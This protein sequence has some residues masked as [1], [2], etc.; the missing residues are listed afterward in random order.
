MQSILTYRRISV[1]AVAALRDE[2]QAA[3][4]AATCTMSSDVMSQVQ[5]LPRSYDRSAQ[6]IHK[7]RLE[8][9][10]A[11]KQSI[12]SQANTSSYTL[13]VALKYAGLNASSCSSLLHTRTPEQQNDKTV[14]QHICWH[15][16][17]TLT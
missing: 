4:A 14:A 2:P 5:A 7:M 1:A 12:T 11:W 9:T 6:P 15:Q 17:Y 16:N 10:G 8:A 13:F 3:C